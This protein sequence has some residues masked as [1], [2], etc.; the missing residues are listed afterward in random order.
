MIL[1]DVILHVTAI[2]NSSYGGF[3]RLFVYAAREFT[4]CYG[5]GIVELPAKR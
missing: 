5:D 4:C 1:K 3:S 2:P